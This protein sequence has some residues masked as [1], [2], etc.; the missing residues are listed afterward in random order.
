MVSVCQV[1]KGFM[2][3][4]QMHLMGCEDI[5]LWCPIVTLLV[6][7]RYGQVFATYPPLVC[8]IARKHSIV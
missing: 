8:R 6:G 5:L 3:R 1:G 7:L 4:L 2:P